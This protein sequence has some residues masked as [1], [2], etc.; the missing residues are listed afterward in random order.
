MTNTLNIVVVSQITPDIP[1]STNFG[2]LLYISN[3]VYSLNTFPQYCVYEYGSPDNSAHTPYPIFTG[4]TSGRAYYDSVAAAALI[5]QANTLMGSA[6]YTAYN[7]TNVDPAVISDLNNYPTIAAMNSAIA[8]AIAAAT[9]P[10]TIFTTPT[11]SNATTATQLSTIQN[12][13]VSYDFDA[14]INISILGGQSITATLTYADNSIMTTNPVIVSSQ[15]TINSGVLGLT[16]S[17]TLKVSG[18]IPKNKYRKVTFAVTN[19][20]TVPTTLKAGQEV[21]L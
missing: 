16:Q 6:Y 17:N 3:D 10:A 12:S 1:D 15:A 7:I 19:S 5:A 2:V 21:Q 18:I 14:S 8:T 13:F 4:D 11:F 20:A 9:P